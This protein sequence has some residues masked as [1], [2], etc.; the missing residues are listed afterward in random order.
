[1]KTTTNITC[2]ARRANYQWT[3]SPMRSFIS[4]LILHSAFILLPLAA[5]AATNN[6][7]SLL[8]QGLFE[9]E[10]N[11]NLDAAIASYQSLATQFN[12][13]RQI[14]ATA[15]F[16]LGECYRKLGQTNEA[17]ME[18][19]RILREFS[20]QQTFVMLSRQN[21]AGMGARTDEAAAGQPTFTTRLMRVLGPGDRLSNS[22]PLSASTQLEQRQ[23]LEREIKLEEQ[24]MA[25]AQKK[26]ETG[27][28]TQGDV[29]AKELAM[30]ELRRRL[31]ALDSSGSQSVPES[32][33][34]GGT[35]QAM[36][37]AEAQTALLEAQL[38]QLKALTPEK[39]RIVV[40]QSYP[41]PVLTKL[42]QDLVEAKQKEA[43]LRADR[44]PENPYVVRAQELVKSLNDQVDQQVDGAL[45]GLK[46]KLEVARDTAK[47]LRAQLEE[48]RAIQAKATSSTA[49]AAETDEE[50]QEIRRIQAMMQNSPDLINTPNGYHPLIR[51]AD[52]GWLKVAAFL[53]DHGA[54]VNAAAAGDSGR[55]FGPTA[56]HQAA[57]FGNK[58]MVELLL[59]RGADVNAKDDDGRTPL[60][61][62]TERGFQAIVEV[63]L[64]NKADVNVSD[65]QSG[66]TPLHRAAESGRAKI[67]QQLLAA[68]ANPNMETSEGRTPLSFAVESGS[69]E[70]VSILLAAKADPSGGRLDAPLLAAIHKQD[71]AS[72]ELLLE[73]GANPNGKG[74]IDW[75]YPLNGTP[76]VT[77]L[78][79]SVSTEQLPMVKLLLKHKADPNDTLFDGRPLL[80]GA[81]FK[82]EILEALLDAG[83]KV[84][85]HLSEGMTPLDLALN[86]NSPVAAVKILLQHGAN[87]NARDLNGNT[88]LHFAVWPTPSVSVA[89]IELLLDHRPDPN[90]RN[91]QG[92]TPLD[93]IKD[94]LA[95]SNI[96][97]GTKASLN[98]IAALLRSHGALDRLPHWDRIT[99]RRP[100]TDFWMTV[101]QEGTNDWNRFT[102]LETILN[103]YE[104]QKMHSSPPYAP[105]AM[106]GGPG[107]DMLPFPDLARVVIV[108]HPRGT[109]NETRL[110]INLLDGANSVD[111]S[112]DMPLEFGDV[113]EIPERE[114]TLAEADTNTPALLKAMLGFLRS[115][116][117]S[118]RLIIDGGQTIQV[119]LDELEPDRCYLANLLQSPQAQNVLTTDSD[120]SRVKVTR[121]DPATGRKREWVLPVSNW[122]PPRNEFPYL[123]SR[124]GRNGPQSAAEPNLWLRDGDVIEVPQK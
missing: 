79:L 43:T 33:S 89:K 122:H 35:A 9:E 45:T 60:Y 6:L 109:T 83:G 78:R 11:R 69:P 21:L 116:A 28:A 123:P 61:L 107:A 1:M 50:D 104:L 88:P 75:E 73:H 10:A 103:F 59:S 65:R 121:R 97:S 22:V 76:S 3:N 51:A 111:G 38:A 23:L 108:R 115:K 71:D 114:H 118:V 92:Q 74:D 95:P 80:F 41:N 16:R 15:V 37:E 91:N 82:P 94:E 17:V 87:P 66:I 68:G 102:L 57:T 86:G 113:V 5:P 18:Y 70:T 90:V 46:G 117:G 93:V 42:M 8:Q 120:P 62:A 124:A 63:L 64:A 52:S 96:D 98:Q 19:R 100:A 48:A 29:R 14:A 40:Q 84:D 106:A 27:L 25:D 47:T 58:A 4:L 26:F 13:D 31:A 99:V 49:A 44:A 24:E 105:Y 7:T 110:K 55:T 34:D 67:V 32:I 85:S 72:A 12:K 2:E 112:R 77:P 39:L 56:L 20:D 81:L 36:A 30:L 101:F 54:D 53:L 119:P